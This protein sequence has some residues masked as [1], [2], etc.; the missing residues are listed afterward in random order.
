MMSLT[1]VSP[2]LQRASYSCFVLP[3]ASCTLPPS[4][5]QHR[6]PQAT[7]SNTL[8]R[9]TATANPGQSRTYATHVTGQDQ[10]YDFPKSMV[11]NE[12]GM[13]ADD[14]VQ[15]VGKHRKRYTSVY[16]WGFT[17]TGALGVPSYF[18]PSN[19]KNP[20]RKPKKF[21][22]IPYKLKFNEK[23]TTASCGYG[24]SLI[25]SHTQ[26]TSKV[27]GM[28][29][30]TNSQIGYHPKA[31]T[32]VE[33]MHTIISPTEITLPLKKPR[34]TRVSQVSCGRSH[35]LIL[36]DE[37]GVYSLGNNSH[38]QCGRPIIPH[39]DY[40]SN[41]VIHK[42]EGIDG[43][44][45]QVCCGHD[46][47]LFLTED[48]HVYSCGWGADGQTGLGHYEDTST[49]QRLEGDIKDEHITQ[50]NTLADCCLAISDKGE[51]FGWGNSEYNQL[52]CVTEDT[53][54]YVP[55]HLP[56]KGIG[57]ITSAATGGTI[58]ALTNESGEVWVWGYGFLG[59]GPKLTDTAVPECIDMSLFGKSRMKT[60]VAVTKVWCGLHY[61]AAV[62][63]KGD[64]YTWGTNGSGCLGL[65]QLHSQYF[66]LKVSLPGQVSHMACSVD[67]SIALVT[68]DI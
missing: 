32:S 41:K 12:T 27:W 11:K 8:C 25:G 45:K 14:V 24:F 28:G 53:Q 59:R 23:I 33:G 63:N 20:I 18:F 2:L 6:S 29:I 67:H 9:D 48:G 22:A 47:S 62:T 26:D 46:H 38:G 43:K 66:P 19:G 68:K 16:V 44:I 61:F 4:H 17:Y 50:I 40:S 65:G 60:D 3:R 56:F 42:I 37:E 35:S 39:E 36:T 15:M 5:L 31:M 55:R 52:K 64:L 10:N 34:K 54:V 30:N 1:Q 51:L 57:K 58:C 49:P 21:Q 7:T 13:Y